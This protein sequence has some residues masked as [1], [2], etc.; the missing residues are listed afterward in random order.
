M[1]KEKRREVGQGV[2]VRCVNRA[3]GGGGARRVGKAC[4]GSYTGDGSPARPFECLRVSGPTPRDGF[5]PPRAGGRSMK[6]RSWPAYLGR[7]AKW[8]GMDSRPLP[9]ASLR[10]RTFRL[11]PDRGA[12]IGHINPADGSELFL[13]W[14]I[15]ADTGLRWPRQL[16]GLYD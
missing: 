9:S 13:L 4:V 16:F 6:G 5:R 8:T 15:L 7:G 2:R 3:L 1:L 14:P 10:R 11:Q 12:G